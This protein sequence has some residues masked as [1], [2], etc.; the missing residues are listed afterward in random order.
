M[1]EIGR[2]LVQSD[3]LEPAD[4]LVVLA[5]DYSG[6]RIKR[7]VEL[8]R[9]G[10]APLALLNGSQQMYLSRECLLAAEYAVS[11]GGEAETEPFCFYAASTLD[12]ARIVDDELLRRGVKSA[13]VV[14]SEFHTRRARLIFR[15][16]TS[17]K[18]RYQFAASPSPGFYPDRWWQSRTGRKIVVLEYLKLLHSTVERAG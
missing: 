16:A 12:E 9:E 7:A 2:F 5:G 8:V 17:G 13:I 1:P 15:Q 10:A 14:T 3:D 6:S 11:I 4:V 18:V